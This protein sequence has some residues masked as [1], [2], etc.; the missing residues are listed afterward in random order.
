AT[1]RAA[2]RGGCAPR[3]NVMKGSPSKYQHR[4]ARLTGQRHKG[5]PE[6][7]MRNTPKRTRGGGSTT[8]T[9]R[10]WSTP[11]M[12]GRYTS[13]RTTT[14]ISGKTGVVTAECDFVSTD[15]NV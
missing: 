15:C 4:R 10:A 3:H 1:V 8:L 5:L 6:D 12:D 9:R 13:G 2:A 7:Q 11:N 14:A